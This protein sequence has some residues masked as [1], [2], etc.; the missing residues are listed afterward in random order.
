MVLQHTELHPII[1]ILLPTPASLAEYQGTDHTLLKAALTL[2]V[3]LS[4]KVVLHLSIAIILFVSNW[5]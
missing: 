5:G 3:V 4:L 2:Q 1:N